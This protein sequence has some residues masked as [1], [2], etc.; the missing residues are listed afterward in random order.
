MLVPCCVYNMNGLPAT[1]VLDRVLVSEGEH[2]VDARAGSWP[3]GTAFRRLRPGSRRGEDARASDSLAHA[4]G[5][6]GHADHHT[7]YRPDT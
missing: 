6:G 4:Y 7:V 2:E 3:A 5:A 1:S